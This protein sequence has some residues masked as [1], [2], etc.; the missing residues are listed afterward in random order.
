MRVSD[1]CRPQ[2]PCNIS[3]QSSVDQDPVSARHIVAKCYE[4]GPR[5]VPA[6]R[7]FERWSRYAWQV[8]KITSGTPSLSG[9]SGT[10]ASRRRAWPPVDQRLVLF[11]NPAPR[12]HSARFRE[13]AR[14]YLRS[15][16]LKPQAHGDCTPSLDHSTHLSQQAFE[17]P[18]P[19]FG[20]LGS[21]SPK[22]H[23]SDS[24]QTETYHVAHLAM[25]YPDVEALRHFSLAGRQSDEINQGVRGR[26]GETT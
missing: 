7:Y 24:V 8:L 19:P 5:N 3:N 11:R 14:F 1:Y 16:P 21:I 23:L 13:I 15:H 10:S 6:V 22:F 2:V 9:S 4:W 26:D 20:W 12:T 17:P 18:Q 25:R